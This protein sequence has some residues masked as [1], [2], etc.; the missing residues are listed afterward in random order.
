MKCSI[1][2]HPTPIL[3]AALCIL[4]LTAVTTRAAEPQPEQP[5]N[6]FDHDILVESFGYGPETPSL[7]AFDDLYQGCPARDCIPSIDDPNYMA[8]AKADF[9]GDD[10]LILGLEIGGEPVAFPVRI[11][12]HH[13]IVNDTIAGQPV[14]I[15]WCPLCGSGV[16]FE[17][18]IDGAVV[19]FGVSGV[20]HDSDLVMYDRATNSLWQQVTGQAIMGPRRGDR[21]ELLPLT[22]TDW[23]T[24]REAHPD[25]RVLSI[26]TDS[27]RDYG[28][29]RRYDAY[30][31]SE[32]LAFPVSGRDLSIHP[33]SVVF[34]FDID[35]EALAVFEERL[36]ADARIITQLGAGELVIERR[37][38]GS[39]RAT[40]SMGNE[41]AP[42][43]LFWFAWYN[44]HPETARLQ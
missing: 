3:L 35:G 18:I 26:P 28:G 13:E 12:D 23:A 30:D 34:G 8:G 9:L 39:V 17:P 40:D 19:E 37:Q 38:D 25:T 33:K 15:T 4:A 10:E 43:R 44:F 6:P 14:A 24:W 32:R 1:R 27:G 31:Q 2:S 20:L 5:R 22:M 29:E 11:L 36:D 7:V 21:L 41:H 42:I 16:A